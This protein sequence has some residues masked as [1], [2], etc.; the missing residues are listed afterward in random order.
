MKKIIIVFIFFVQIFSLN[1]QNVTILPSGITPASTSTYP[2]ISYDAILA[3]PSPVKGDMAYDIT[4]DC[5]RIYTGRKWLCTYQNP[6]DSTPNIM[7][8]A[9]AGGTNDDLGYSI[10]VDGLGNVYITGSYNSTATFGSTTI[11][12]A[13]SF[14]IF[15]ARLDN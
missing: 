3:L 11:T 15:V 13:G 12:S 2:R 1:A 8:F 7:P 5:L 4:F 10:A 14:D 6:A 9:S